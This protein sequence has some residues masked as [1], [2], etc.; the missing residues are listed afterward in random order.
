MSKV[1]RYSSFRTM[2]AY[3]SLSAWRQKRKAMTQDFLAKQSAASDAFS[4]TWS[5]QITGMNTIIGQ[6][7]LARVTAEGKAKAAKQADDAANTTTIDTNAANIQDSA[8]SGDGTGELD[9][10]TM[11]DLNAGTITLSDGTVIDSQTGIKKV[12]LSV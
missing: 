7:A 11:I 9:S 4:S 2:T 3:E 8:F 12:D 6:I 1:S 10:G 5:D